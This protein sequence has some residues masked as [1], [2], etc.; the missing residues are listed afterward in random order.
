MKKI[1]VFALLVTFLL[2]GCGKEVGVIGG[3]DGPTDIV[4]VPEDDWGI[5]MYAENVTP[6]GVKVVC[7]QSGGFYKGELQTGTPWTLEYEEDGEWKPCPTKDGTELIWTMIA[8][9]IKINSTTEWVM[10]FSMHYEP[11]TAGK[12]RIGKVITDF[13]GDGDYANRTYYA[14]FTIEAE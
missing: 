14:N 13:K 6:T 8:Q 12:Y 7:E 4:I 11:L 5:S 9:K 3:A 2:S 1:F 10:D